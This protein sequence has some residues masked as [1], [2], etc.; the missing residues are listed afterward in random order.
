[1][2]LTTNLYD[3]FTVGNNISKLTVEPFVKD[4]EY[5]RYVYEKSEINHCPNP[6][7]GPYRSLSCTHN[8]IL[9]NLLS[10][11]VSDY[12]TINNCMYDIQED[13]ALI[14]VEN[15]KDWLAYCHVCFPSGWRPIDVIGRSFAE[16]HKTVPGFVFNPKL[17]ETLVT[18]NY[19]RFV[20]SPIYENKLNQ[21]PGESRKFSIDNPQFWLKIEKQV[22][23]G[24]PK[25]NCFVFIMRQYI[26]DVSKIDLD[27]FRNTIRNMSLVQREY[28]NITPEFERY[29]NACN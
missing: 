9:N 29:I 27:V 4:C 28:K 12:I 14:R 10:D 7:A 15:G 1:M 3:K 19:Q 6:Y 22:T 16:T 18:G 11:L 24:Y 23:L 21:Y 25:E 2:L 20:W 17:I 5:E 13:I 26:Y 8:N